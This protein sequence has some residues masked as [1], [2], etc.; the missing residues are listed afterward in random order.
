MTTGRFDPGRI[1]LAFE[2]V[3]DVPDGPLGVVDSGD[4][5][6]RL[7][8]VTQAGRIWIVEDGRRVEKPFLDI[9][10][11]ITTGGERGL[12]GL[13][14]HPNF[15]ETPVFYVNYTDRNGNTVV[16]EFNVSSPN[17]NADP[18]SERPILHV[19][20]PFP[21]HNGGALQFGP[22]GDLYVSLGDGGSGGDPLGNGQKL[23]TLLGKILRIDPSRA[24][25]G[26]PYGVPDDNPFVGRNDAKP[27]IWLYGLRNPWRISFD[28]QTGDLW[29]GDVG[30]GAY[31]EIDVARAGSGGGANFGWNRMEGF[32]CFPSGDSCDKNGL[33]L[34]VTEVAHGNGDCSIIGGYVYRGARYPALQGAYLFSDYCTGR[35][36]A[37]DPTAKR[38]DDPAVVL[39]SK[40][41]ISSFGEDANGELY[42]TDLSGTLLE[43]T[44]SSP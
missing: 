22:D 32:H 30:Q 13:A 41:Q 27:E 1:H 17:G 5:S 34:P 26:R 14:F 39:E 38:V 24:S 36:W 2:P 25:A 3:V 6:D 31:E 9:S 23:S 19:E 21:N 43:V 12:L 10:D 18:A 35:V 29:I 4:G 8:V 33:T 37:I 20:Q 44:A 28:R 42:V 15:P 40:R 7:F 11:E 16:S